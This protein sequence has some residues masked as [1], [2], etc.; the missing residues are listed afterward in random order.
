MP[1]TSYFVF[2]RWRSRDGRGQWGWSSHQLSTQWFKVWTHTPEVSVPEE[3]NFLLQF[4]LK[5]HFK[6]IFVII[7][8]NRDRTIN[9]K[10][11]T[12][13][14]SFC[15]TNFFSWLRYWGGWGE[16][17]HITLSI[18]V[19]FKAINSYFH[20]GRVYILLF[21]LKFSWKNTPVLDQY[22]F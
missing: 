4:P 14:P 18:L 3:L 10:L 17:R 16:L 13:S 6:N 21:L 9:D 15:D 19:L 5:F 7:E 1:C 12:P 11:I 8:R 2:C 20:R 22:F